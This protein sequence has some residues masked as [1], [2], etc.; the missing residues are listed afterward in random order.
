MNLIIL[1]P[2]PYPMVPSPI[3]YGHLF[4]QNNGPNPQNLHGVL[5]P[6]RISGMGILLASY[7]LGGP[8]K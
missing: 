4:F 1:L 8:K 3:P 6:N 7:I 2:T 5:K